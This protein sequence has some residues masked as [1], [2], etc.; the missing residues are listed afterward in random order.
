M[1]MTR[2]FIDVGSRRVHYRRCGSGPAFLM[3]HQSPRSSA[4]F[5]VLMRA[6]GHHF[7]CIAPDSPGFGQSDPLP[8]EPGIDD[9]ADATVALLDALGLDQVAGYGFH[10]GGIILVTALRRR[11]ERFTALAIGGYA[12]WTPDERAVFGEHYLPPFAPSAYG[13]HLTWLWG[14][15]LEQSWFFPWFDVRP[16][17][18]LGVAHDDPA[19]VHAT[20]IDMLASGDAYRAGYGAVLNAPRDIPPP[21]AQTPPVLITAYDGDPL[22]AHLDRLG[23]MPANWQ[24]RAVATPAEHQAESAAFLAGNPAPAPATLNE[25]TDEGF[26]RIS[27]GGF[28]G[29]IHWR[30][31]GDR[32]RVHAPGRAAGEG[33]LAIDLPGH[34]LS[35]DWPG[36]RP[37]EWAPWAAVIEA[38][39]QAL[40][41]RD[42]TFDPLPTGDPDRLFPDLAPDRF[43]AYLTIAWQIVRAAHF[44][45]PWYE[46]NAAHTRDF[47]ADAI[48][49]EQLAREHR[50][51]LNARAA[52][53]YLIAR[54][55]HEGES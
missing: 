34:G 2:H 40:G 53:A 7:T 28:D 49:P 21:D 35:D 10:S 31:R 8:G 55:S 5:E 37:R 39:R 26:V 50:D 30:G 43:G 4:E 11:P 54:R 24:T 48:A 29:L 6:W 18:R 36:P 14:R 22:Q 47:S 15:I 23:A 27:T 19:R 38:T 1:E 46:A 25:A 12:V 13:E 17:T 32:L 41:A 16:E 3:V 33:G 45:D 20:I 9:F 44:Y 52:R 51:L 42:V